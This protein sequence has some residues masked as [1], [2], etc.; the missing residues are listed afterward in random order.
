MYPTLF[1]VPTPIG[2]LDDIT[3]RAIKV[4]QSVDVVLCE[5][6]R[7]SVKLIQHLGI[8]VALKAFHQHNEHKILTEIV[9]EI[10]KG[11]KY[12]LISDAGTP[13]ISDPGFLLTRACIQEGIVVDCLP[14]PTAF[15]PAL[16]MSALPCDKFYFE[17]FLPHKKGRNKRLL[18]LKELD[19]SVI[20]YESPYRIV[21]LLEELKALF[22]PEFKLVVVREIS[23]IYQSVHRGTVDELLQIMQKDKAKGEMV[24]LWNSTLKNQE[25]F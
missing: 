5:D 17:G 19:C 15:V 18:F 11:K 9:D 16:V 25:A 12:A 13:G 14:G 6:T 23:K 4:L 22:H 3:L 10:K 21:K 20:L 7:H 24:V 1:L 8:E 2:N